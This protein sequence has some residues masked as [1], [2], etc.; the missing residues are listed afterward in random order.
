LITDLTSFP[1]G[2]HIVV[3]RL[4]GSIDLIEELALK[5]VLCT[6]KCKSDR[7]SL[8]FKD[9]LHKILSS[10]GNKIGSC[11]SIIG[12]LNRNEE[13][14]PFAAYSCVSK[15][16]KGKIYYD[17][18]ISSGV[19]SGIMNLDSILSENVKKKND[20]EVNVTKAL[21]K[22][23]IVNIYNN[24]AGY[25]DSVNSDILSGF[26]VYRI[27]RWKFKYLTFINII[28]HNARLFY[29]LQM[30]NFFKKFSYN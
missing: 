22:N 14:V 13:N 1:E 2:S 29:K 9:F 3:D 10:K 25:V 23:C 5:K 16:E 24:S 28:T 4:Y 21:W 30:K 12:K 8:F 7:P 6:A 11:A 27:M 18:F 19:V 17:N 26:P 20:S 15:T